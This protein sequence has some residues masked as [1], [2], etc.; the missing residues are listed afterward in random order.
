[1]ERRE[2]EENGGDSVKGGKEVNAERGGGEDGGDGGG[3][4]GEEE[5]KRS[6]VK[7]YWF[8]RSIHWLEGETK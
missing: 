1:M 3:E 4:G 7:A 2:V 6:E 5:K 8:Q